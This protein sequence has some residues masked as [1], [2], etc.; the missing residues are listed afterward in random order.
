MT[1]NLAVVKKPS[2]ESSFAHPAP[3]WLAAQM[4]PVYRSRFEEIQRLAAEIQGM[5]RMGRLLWEQGATL[6]EVVNEAFASLK[7]KPEWNDDG[8]C[9]MVRVDPARRVLVH[10]VTADGPLERNSEGVANA[11]KVLQTVAG[12]D[13]RIVLV[14]TGQRTLPPHERGET[15]SAEAAELLRRMGV[16]VLPCTTLFN[17]WMLSLTNM[18]EARTYL[19]LLH[20]QD[21][22]TFKTKS[23]T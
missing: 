8:S 9:L 17:I 23:R 11:F 19:E 21:G 6:K 10:V 20:S 4:P 14:T 2:Q 15:V 18:S 22:G 7:T 1:P 13:D 12:S 5:D 16:N 3:S